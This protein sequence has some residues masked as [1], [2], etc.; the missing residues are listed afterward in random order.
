MPTPTDACP[1]ERL[2]L[3]KV[4]YPPQTA[5]LT[6]GKVFKYVEA[7][8]GI[9]LIQTTTRRNGL[10]VLGTQSILEGLASWSHGSVHGGRHVQLVL[11]T[12]WRIRKQGLRL[13]PEEDIAFKNLTVTNF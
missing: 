5:P 11:L 12:S 1:S 9:F 6:W 10:T 13:E 3:P 8:G 4:P 2:H 7:Y